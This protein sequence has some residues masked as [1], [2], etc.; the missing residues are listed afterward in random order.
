M[1][2]KAGLLGVGCG[3]LLVARSATA[4]SFDRPSD[5]IYCYEAAEGQDVPG[6]GSGF[7]ALDGT[8][9]HDNGSDAWD[10]SAIGAGSPGG[11]MVIDGTYLRLQETGDPTDYGMPDPSNRKIYLGHNLTADGASDA[12]L[13]EGVTMHFRARVPTD[14]PLDDRHPDGGGGITPYPAEGDGYSLHNGGK[15]NVGIKQRSGGLISFSLET[16]GDSAGL[17][18]NGLGNVD[19]TTNI[20]DIDVTEWHDYYVTISAGDAGTHQVSVYVDGSSTPTTFDVT[21]GN[22][23]DF[24]DMTYVALGLGAT[25][26]SGALDVDYVCVAAGAQPPGGAPA[27]APL[28]SGWGLALLGL[29]MAAGALVALRRRPG[30]ASC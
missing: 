10:G 19:A 30:L 26:E 2:R 6:A 1:L 11:A 23:S 8:F 20:L 22:G 25:G 13:D 7:D 14:G 4:Q 12:L 18:V 9:S 5:L 28:S 24:A 21:A 15:G 27:Q 29:L 16:V 17:K 3:L